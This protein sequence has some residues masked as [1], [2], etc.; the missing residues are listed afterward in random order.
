MLTPSARASV[1][2]ARRSRGPARAPPDTAPR[3][4]AHR[5]RH[6]SGSMVREDRDQII[7]NIKDRT[8]TNRD[9]DD[10][11]VAELG[12]ECVEHTPTF[13]IYRLLHPANQGF[14][15]FEGQL[16]RLVMI[17]TVGY[18][19]ADQRLATSVGDEQPPQPPRRS[20]A[21]PYRSDRRSQLQ[22]VAARHPQKQQ[23]NSATAQHRPRTG[24]GAYRER[25]PWNRRIIPWPAVE[26]GR[27]R[28]D[29]GAAEVSTSHSPH[30]GEEVP[31]VE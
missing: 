9:R 18:P 31:C 16:Q 26:T 23:R 10:P 2:H 8:A 13:A 12:H 21:R 1:G 20:Q 28:Y 19:W 11:M 30:P 29:H 22:L 24:Q 4:R 3:D 25:W 17:G 6:R 15:L 14:G 7:G 27:L 5:R